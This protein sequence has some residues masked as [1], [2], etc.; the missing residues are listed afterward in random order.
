MS[1]SL[2]VYGS[3]MSLK[4]INRIIG[5]IPKSSKAELPHFHRYKIKDKMYPAI[6]EKLDGIVD[7]I[8]FDELENSDIVK[9][10][11]YESDE[12]VRKLVEVNVNFE[13]KIVYT[14]IWNSNILDL[15]STWNYNTDFAPFEEEF[16][17]N[18]V[19]ERISN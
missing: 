12:Y 1:N 9:L 14:Y 15:Y 13:K 18:D 16:L 11:I 8:L 10:D 4:V 17:R 5:R 7:G 6:S 2:F 3:L 19:P